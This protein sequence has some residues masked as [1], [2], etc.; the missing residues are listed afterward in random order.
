MAWFKC[1]V[2]GRRLP[3]SQVTVGGV[4]L[5]VCPYCSLLLATYTSR[6]ARRARLEPDEELIE[7]FKGKPRSRKEVS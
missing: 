2:C 7:R 5:N 6:P 4:T 3:L 1:D